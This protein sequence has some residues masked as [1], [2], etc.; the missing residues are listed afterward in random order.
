VSVSPSG[1]VSVTGGK[2]TTYRRMAADTVDE[3]V[4]VLGRGRRRSPTGSLP[5]RGAAGTAE[6]RQDGASTRLGVDQP[7]VDHLVGRY[8][9]EARAVLAM[10]HADPAM[11]APLVEGLPY[12][13]AEAVYAARYEMA[14]TLDDVLSRRMRATLHEQEATADAA[15]E[16]ADLVAPE[17]GWT[18]AEVEHQ[19]TAFREAVDG[20]RVAARLARPH[21]GRQ[22]A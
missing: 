14:H 19:V 5:L 17:L 6:L 13:R 11:G 22:G 2:L 21:A 4:Q 15:A 16:I 10:M 9:G 3:V 18:P 8:G 12:L 7:V 20:D 1:V